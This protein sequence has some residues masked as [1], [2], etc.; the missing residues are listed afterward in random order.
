MINNLKLSGVNNSCF[1]IFRDSVDLGQ[2]TVRMANLHSM[3]SGDSVSKTPTTG[4]RIFQRL[5][6]SHIWCLG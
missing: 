5:L 6:L 2:G 3:V 1:I 4:A